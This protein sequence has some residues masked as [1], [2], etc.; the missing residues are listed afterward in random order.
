MLL[1]KE[2][3]VCALFGDQCCT[4]IPNNTALDGSLTKAL[5]GLRTLNIKMKEHSG[6]DR[7][8]WGDWLKVFGQYKSLVASVLLSVAVFAA[9]LTLCGCCCIPCIR[10]LL[11]RLITTAIAP[12]TRDPAQML[13]LLH[14]QSEVEEEENDPERYENIKL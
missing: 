1:A 5:E 10:A 7:T 3:G 4:F 6:V 9:L 2:G 13:P 12:T 8:M 14:V 11:N